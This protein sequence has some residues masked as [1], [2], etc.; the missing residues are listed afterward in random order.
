MTYWLLNAVFLG[1]V[2]ALVIAVVVRRRSPQLRAIAIT[3]GIL[4][5]M[6]AV[7][8]NVMISVGLV[9]Y[10][11]EA[12]SGAFIGVAPLEDFAYTIAAVVGLPCLWMLL[13][14][15]RKDSNA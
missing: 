7:F 14:S 10:S 3:M 13:G 5:V 4:L 6:T 12:I 9:G 15:R 11:A 2:A 8:D 1:L